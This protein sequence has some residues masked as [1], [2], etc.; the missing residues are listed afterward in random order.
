MDLRDTLS[1][2][3]VAPKK[4]L[5]IVLGLA[6]VL[7]LMWLF[8]LSHIDY[9][10]DPDAE[11]VTITTEEPADSSAAV[12]G[13][14]AQKLRSYSK[15]SGGMFSSGLLTFM[16]LLAILIGIWFWLDRKNPNQSGTVRRAVGSENLGEGA[17][18]KIVQINNEI[19]ILGVTSASVNLLHRYPKNEWQ[20]TAPDNDQPGNDMFAKL[21]RSQM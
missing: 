20:E 1:S 3:D 14:D 17:K 5:K 19:W 10:G 8:T 4:V 7:L 2:L 15:S 18:L 9:N 11:K 6:V 12:S 16:V 21:F 13:E